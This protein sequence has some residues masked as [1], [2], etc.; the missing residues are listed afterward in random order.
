MA[1]NI[2]HIRSE[3]PTLHQNVNG[4]PL[5]YFDNAATS[6]KPQVVIDCINQYYTKENSN[7]H[8]GVHYL[9]QQ[10]TDK[11]QQGRED[12][13]RFINASSTQEII[14]TKGTTDAINLVATSLSKSYFKPGNEILISA[15]EHHSNIV[16]WQI[17]CEHTGAVLKVIPILDSGELDMSAFDALLGNKTALLAISHISN[18]LGTINPIKEMIAKAKQY[19]ALTLIDGA[20]SVAHSK[21]DVQDLNC[22]FFCFSAHKMFGP[23][24]IGVLFGKKEILTE[25]P[26]YQGGGEMIKEVRFE[27]TTYN[28]L[29]FKFEAGTPHISGGIGLGAAV[30]YIESLDMEALGQH[31]HELLDYATQELKAL[32]GIRFIGEAKEKTGLVSFIMKDIH[33]YDAG[34]VLD[35]L[36]IAIRTGHVC[37]QPVMDRYNIPGIMRASFAVYNTKEE[38]DIM[39]KGLKRIQSMFS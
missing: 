10:A 24:G 4:K 22:D 23:T 32:S 29:P 35:K 26:P 12:V 1:L 11:Y 20:Q 18:A 36:G 14:I 16:P 21:V 2:D 31:Q 3:F 37:A 6:H 33:P 27:G 19:N 8:R 17:A 7:I 15:L 25:I 34:T 13:R 9:S 28:E 38:V 5:V 30:R 39:I